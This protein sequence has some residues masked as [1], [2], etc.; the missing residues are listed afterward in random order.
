M[1]IA[2][3]VRLDDLF[4]RPGAAANTSA[5]AIA[6]LAQLTHYRVGVRAIAAMKRPAALRQQ[7]E[8][9]SR[10]GD[11]DVGRSH[12]AVLSLEAD[13]KTPGALTE[14]GFAAFEDVADCLP[15]FRIFKSARHV[16]DWWQSA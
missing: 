5:Y 10:V 3:A 13:A 4:E 16:A 14:G 8:R 15:D 6:E 2:G 11:G 9:L 7:V 1:R 12:L